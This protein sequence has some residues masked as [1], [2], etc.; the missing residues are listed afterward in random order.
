MRNAAYCFD[1]RFSVLSQSLSAQG[2]A[3]RGLQCRGG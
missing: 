1:E 2:V 3:G